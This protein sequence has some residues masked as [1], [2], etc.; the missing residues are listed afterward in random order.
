MKSPAQPAKKVAQSKARSKEARLRELREAKA[1]PSHVDVMLD[2]GWPLDLVILPG[3]RPPRKEKPEHSFDWDGAPAA[4]RNQRGPK[5]WTNR[6]TL[7]PPPRRPK[8]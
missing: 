5:R 7:R 4:T 8:Q 3:E 6:S 2:D 1:L